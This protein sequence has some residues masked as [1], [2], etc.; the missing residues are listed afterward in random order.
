MPPPIEICSFRS[1]CQVGGQSKQCDVIVSSSCHFLPVDF[2]DTCKSISHSQLTNGAINHAIFALIRNFPG[3]SA[4]CKASLL[5][6]LSEMVKLLLDEVS[7]GKPL[8]EAHKINA[9][10]TLFYFIQLVHK[11]EE[12]NNGAGTTSAGNGEKKAKASKK[13]ADK[14]SD[15]DWTSSLRKKSLVIIKDIV[16]ADLGQLWTMGLVEENFLKSI[17]SYC[18]DL[19]V[20]RPA[21]ISGAGNVES[22]SRTLVT[23]ILGCIVKHFGSVATSGSYCAVA[24]AL[25]DAI[26]RTEHM[27]TVVGEI[28]HQEKVNNG[29]NIFVTNELIAE[30]S[31]MNLGL[32][33]A[34]GVKNISGFVEAYAKADPES[35]THF[36]P[37]LIKQSD[38]PAHQMRSAMIQAISHVIEY[39]RE[40]VAKKNHA[41]TDNENN[42]EE[43]SPNNRQSLLRQ[44]D[45][46]LN[47]LIE[48]TH[49]IN[50]YT[51]ACLLKVWANLVDSNAVPV[52]RMGSVAEVALDRLFDKNA[53]VRR[54]AIILFTSLVDCN[55]FTGK[56]DM[57]LFAQQKTELEKMI[58]G[59]LQE[60]SEVMAAKLAEKMEQQKL[61]RLEDKAAGI[62]VGEDEEEDVEE[63]DEE[64]L[65]ADAEADDVMVDLRAKHDYVNAATEFMKAVSQAVPR[66]ASMLES[67]NIS[68]VVESLSFLGRAINFQV[69]GS[70][71]EFKNAFKL[72][73]HHDSTVRSELQSVFKQV[74]FTDGAKEHARLLSSR[75][76]AFNLT[77]LI[78]SCNS[79]HL[80]SLEEIVAESGRDFEA[81]DEVLEELLALGKLQPVSIGGSQQHNLLAASMQA[82]S[83]LAL[84]GESQCEV[85]VGMLPHILGAG[86][87]DENL[88]KK[89]F[90]TLRAT[91]ICINRIHQIIQKQKAS[92]TASGRAL[93][94]PQDMLCDTIISLQK[95]VTWAAYLT[96]DVTVQAWFSVC[97]EAIHAI[98]KLHEAPEIIMDAVIHFVHERLF[99]EDTSG[100][101]TQAQ[102]AAFLFVLGQTAV[103]GVVYIEDIAAKVKTR[104]RE[105]VESGK[106]VDNTG[107]SSNDIASKDATKG[108]EGNLADFE[109]QMGV[110]AAVDAEHDQEVHVLIEHELVLQNLLGAFLPLVTFVTAND[111]GQFSAPV[112]HDTAVLTLCRYMT[113]SSIACESSLPVLFT[114]LERE[115]S[116]I[117]RTT[118]TVALGDLAF[119]FPNTFEPWTNRLYARLCDEDADVRYNTMVVITHLVLNDMIKVK[120]QVSHVAFALNDRETRVRDLARLFFIKL[121][122]RSNNPVFNLLGDIISHFSREDVSVEENKVS[123]TAADFQATMHFLL[124][125]VQK[126]KHADMLLERLLI[127]LVA[128]ESTLQ[129]QNLAYCISELTVTEKGLKKLVEMIKA[130]KVALLDDVVLQH[131]RT[132]L[133]RAKKSR[134]VGSSS[135]SGGNTETAQMSADAAAAGGSEGASGAGA[136]VISKSLVEEVEQALLAA[137][138]GN[139]NAVHIQGLS[140]EDATEDAVDTS[141]TTGMDMTSYASLPLRVYLR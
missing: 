139:E 44:R 54:N 45:T 16:I 86:L 69:N 26:I 80:T 46:L 24:T 114:V 15:F 91:I 100:S 38:S 82:I 50:P 3:L 138:A 137:I 7:S 84:R 73:W 108:A 10:K 71:D 20:E 52:R 11:A 8:T 106:H 135:S 109:E 32:V 110:A 133:G 134:A 34:A 116:S 12:S 87:S 97:E 53:F 9:K 75:E 63:L 113:I 121:S 127:R 29:A 58:E 99:G 72:I 47:I 123:L 57:E 136:G 42:R 128:A 124:S 2:V 25:L 85:L 21:G 62:A 131:V 49:D 79:V 120:G 65:F 18:I 92:T 95:I 22:T 103:N 94:Y 37:N 101:C 4:E 129:R 74:Y 43:L 93:V 115:T 66:I 140:G 81:L 90:D 104:L 14:A 105:N 33:S 51:R 68:D 98:F 119:R 78:A 55:P 23:Q 5:E 107:S 6:D 125:F 17:W 39:I 35:F 112:L 60:L 76:I 27:G 13:K 67:K 19:L 56:L 36:M 102:L 130:I 141:P 31:K 40:V 89:D 96:L 83:M 41:E 88:A 64:E 48:R 1:P 118:I 126:D 117:L 77:Q 28:C 30:I 111:A 70:L 59:R 61:A 122:E 132:M